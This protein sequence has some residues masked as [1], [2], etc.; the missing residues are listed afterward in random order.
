MYRKM[1]SVVKV[2][3]M[4]FFHFVHFYN[5]FSPIHSNPVVQCKTLEDTHLGPWKGAPAGDLSQKSSGQYNHYPPPRPP[6]KYHYKPMYKSSAA[7]AS[8]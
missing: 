3:G 2:K 5:S 1:H 4:M 7:A 6:P 8:S